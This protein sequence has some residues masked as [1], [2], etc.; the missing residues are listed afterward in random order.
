MRDID[1]NKIKRQGTT[2]WEV[3]S[4]AAAIRAF[5]KRWYRRRGHEVFCR[6]TSKQTRG[7]RPHQKGCW[8]LSRPSQERG[9]GRYLLPAHLFLPL[10]LLLATACNVVDDRELCCEEVELIYRYVRTDKTGD[11]YSTF[12]TSM[13][14]F[15]YDEEGHFLREVPSL[16]GRPQRVR[17]KDLPVGH[18]TM[19]TVG[20]A[21]EER[22]ALQAIQEGQSLGSALLEVT[23]NEG[24]EAPFYG[25]ADQLFYNLRQFESV[26]DKKCTYYCDLSNIHCHLYVKVRWKDHDPIYREGAYQLRQSHVTVGYHLSETPLTITIKRDSLESTPHSTYKQ[27]IHHFPRGQAELVE[28]AS[29]DTLFNSRLYYSFVTPRYTNSCYPVLQ[30]FHQGTP[31]SGLVDLQKAFEA[32]GWVPDED[33]EQIYKIEMVVDKDG[34]VELYP[35]TDVHVLDWEDGGTFG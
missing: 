17:L 3:P 15:L 1:R 29:S 4:V 26:V 6:A 22:T 13:R 31:V 14:H 21:T 35:W 2:T 20:N 5:V 23:T 11:E 25:D 12:L 33:P 19:L 8:L 27:V 34:R 7:G 9:V 16:P 18:Y 28:Y 10:L 24:E 30:L 32:W